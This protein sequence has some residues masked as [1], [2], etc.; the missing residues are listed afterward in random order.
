M[1][2]AIRKK[3]AR[4]KQQFQNLHEV[5]AHIEA[6]RHEA[7]ATSDE[8]ARHMEELT[9]HKPGQPLDAFEVVK[10]VKNVF[11]NHYVLRDDT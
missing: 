1:K 10:L 7:N 6:E 4:K 8:C 3:T 11:D 9:G 2:Q 5:V